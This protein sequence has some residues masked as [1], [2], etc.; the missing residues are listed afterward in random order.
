MRQTD[1]LDRMLDAWLD[2]PYSVPTPRILGKVLERTSRT[3]QR[4]AWASLERW[5]PM[6]VI[7]RP[8]AAAPSLRIAWIL[9]IALLALSLAAGAAIVGSRLLPA[10]VAIP[11]GDA[12]VIAYALFGNGPGQIAGDIYTARADGTDVRHV[13]SGFVDYPI[14]S[15]DGTR[16]AF[17]GWQNGADSLVVMDA[18]GGNQMTLASNPATS[19]DCMGNWSTAWS[20]DGA[21][22]LFPT[23]ESCFGGY[24]L[25]IVPADGSTPARKLLADGTNSLFGSWSPD[26][27]RIALLGSEATGKTGL[28]LVDVGPDGGLAGGLQAH[29]IASDIGVTLSTLQ[30][31]AYVDQPRWSPDGTEL[32]V[33]SVTKGV[34]IEAADG[35]LIVNADGSGQ[36]LLTAR[37]GNPAWSPNG[38]HVAFQRTVD[39]SE[40]ANHRPCTVRTWI[41]DQDGTNERRLDELGDGCGT[42]EVWSPDGTRIASVLITPQPGQDPLFRFGIVMVDGSKPPVILGDAYGSWQPVAAPLP[43]MSSP[44][45]S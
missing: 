21:N 26:G 8:A 37:A 10:A 7:T 19:Q 30:F 31:P 43:P 27:T 2:D 13:T 11:Q 18:G 36:R 23:R 25:N 12:A 22:L 40:Y 39:P 34:F 17:H 33:T 35:I 14:W 3:R 44:S 24:D 32:A 38:Q 1:D 20:P 5:L 42:P 6:A 28:Y 45:P 15:P 9:L 29:R 41:I 16:I 4:R